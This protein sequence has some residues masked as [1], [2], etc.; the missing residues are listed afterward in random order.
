MTDRSPFIDSSPFIDCSIIQ[1]AETWL[2]RLGIDTTISGSSQTRTAQSTTTE[3]GSESCEVYSLSRFR[4][5]QNLANPNSTIPFVSIGLTNQAATY[6][7][8]RLFFAPRP[9]ETAHSIGVLSSRLGQALEKKSDWFA[10][11]RTLLTQINST[12]RLLTASGTTA[13]P[14]VRRGAELFGISLV[15]F[16]GINTKRMSWTRFL[17][18]FR[19]F[20]DS[21]ESCGPRIGH[22]HSQALQVF[23]SPELSTAPLEPVTEQSPD[24]FL[25]S[26]ASRLCALSIRRNGNVHRAINAR[27]KDN[28]RLATHRET[29]I[30]M[31]SSLSSKTIQSELLQQG[32][33]GWILQNRA[34]AKSKSTK[35]T[36]QI[37]L[38]AFD[39]SRLLDR[40]TINDDEFLI[41]WTRRCSSHWPDLQPNTLADDLIFQSTRANRDGFATLCRILAG[42]YLLA[43]TA[44]T[45][46]S[47]PVVCFSDIPITSLQQQTRFRPHLARWDCLPF[48]IAIRKNVLARFGARPVIYSSDHSW[49]QLPDRDPP[50]FST[51]S[52][53]GQNGLAS[54]TRMATGRRFEA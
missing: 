40:K 32:A 15:E 28:R 27:L 1:R 34:E 46:S 50:L 14:Y 8:A 3:M 19:Q 11:I 54:R 37:D 29:K 41:H 35:P 45:R 52:I 4:W 51:G 31:N 26:L 13:D 6:T 7:P 25:A 18:T 49:E 5:G 16:V 33:V 12:E 9:V 47:R 53:I 23:V 42:G 10:A 44:L 20:S 30:L 48:G 39:D 22:S 17:G 36:N 21:L 2:T 24:L 43:T 38:E